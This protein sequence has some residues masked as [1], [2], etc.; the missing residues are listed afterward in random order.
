MASAYT[1][2]DSME[3][4][5][6]RS[7]VDEFKHSPELFSAEAITYLA[8]FVGWLHA[9]RNG[10]TALLFF[11]LSFLAASLVDPICLISEEVRNYYHSHASVLM[12]DRHV[13]PWQF[14]LFCCIA[15][16]PGA[17]VWSLGLGL[18]SE[19]LL[20]VF[21]SSWS[22]YCFDMF[23]C[24]WL[25]YQWHTNDPLYLAKTQCVPLASSMWVMCYAA[26]ASLLSRKLGK[27]SA[28][29]LV[30]GIAVFL[31]LHIAPIAVLYFPVHFFEL[32]LE[33]E[34]V[35][36]F[37]LACLLGSVVVHLSGWE[38]RQR[39]STSGRWLALLQ[40]AV[41]FGGVF[42]VLQFLDPSHVLS[43]AIHQPYGGNKENC[44]ETETYLFGLGERRRYLCEEDLVTWKLGVNPVTQLPPKPKEEYYVIRGLEMS[45]E[46]YLDMANCI[47][48]GFAQQL[49]LVLLSFAFVR[50]SA[51]KQKQL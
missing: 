21:V 29:N 50:S 19:T 34:V 40:T 33:F 2:K 25:L 31:P 35:W 4:Y 17:A 16:I 45:R 15:Y 46:F 22:F 7:P 49:L 48:F 51:R 24:K 20:M 38:E 18:V 9:R 42:L 1:G 26:T 8:C 44:A 32:H 6:L 39:A 5:F 11:W 36:G 13:A 30:V 37:A 41:W 23:A 47:G 27:L 14:P 10:Q 12:F 43:Y 28:R 3:F